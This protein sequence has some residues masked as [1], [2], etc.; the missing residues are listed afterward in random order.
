[1]L[2]VVDLASMVFL[3]CIETG[4]RSKRQGIGKDPNKSRIK[5]MSMTA[6]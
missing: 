3:T 6:L 4:Q 5:Q 2:E 1:M